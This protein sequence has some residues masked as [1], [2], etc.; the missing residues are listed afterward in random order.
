MIVNGVLFIGDW[1]FG[2]FLGK[3]A[4]PSLLLDACP[5]G[6]LHRWGRHCEVDLVVEG[7]FV[8]A[9]R[10]RCMCCYVGFEDR[11]VLLAGSTML[12]NPTR[13]PAGAG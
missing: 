4:S 6:E 7:A 12:S 9:P 5:V 11:G 8:L 3:L 2:M 10:A 13:V 1:R